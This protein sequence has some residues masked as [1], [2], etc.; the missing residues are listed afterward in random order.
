MTILQIKKGPQHSYIKRNTLYIYIYSILDDVV[1][2][3]RVAELDCQC[4][5]STSTFLQLVVTPL[6]E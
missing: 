4:V 5:T 6:V 1:Q 2:P 3:L